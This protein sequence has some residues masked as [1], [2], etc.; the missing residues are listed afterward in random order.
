[1]CMDIS[2][3]EDWCVFLMVFMYCL[4]NDVNLVGK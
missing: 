3:D 2:Q 4:V 1:M